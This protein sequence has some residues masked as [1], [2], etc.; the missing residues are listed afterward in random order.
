[1][2]GSDARCPFCDPDQIEPQT[3]TQTQHLS[4]LADLHP[5]ADGHLLIVTRDH[6]PCVAALPIPYDSE[7]EGL[8]AATRSFLADRY[9]PTTILEHGSVAQTVPHA[10]LHLI[11]NVPD[12]RDTL[13]H[14]RERNDTDG[15]PALRRWFAERGPYLYYA[16]DDGAS[17]FPPD[18]DEPGHLVR[19]AADAR[20]AGSPAPASDSGERAARRLRSEWQHFQSETNGAAA[21]VVACFLERDGRLALFKRSARVDSAP[22][23]WH[24]VAGYL[25]LGADPLDHALTEIGEETGLSREQLALRSAGEAFVIPDA[26]RR[27]RWRVHPFLFRVL[28]GEPHLNWEHD[29]LAWV[30]PR[31]IPAYRCM[32][33]VGDVYE[34]LDASAR[35]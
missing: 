3:V 9:G 17:I 14:G 19:L 30:E 10:H 5:I 11:P 31:M 28:D 4:L 23:R 29:E 16:C 20:R 18:R 27:I 34:S 25:P 22:G 24:V 1:M 2:S 26:F 12:F 35:G 32:P 13:A 33:W 7:L 6:L 21:D 8:I 15:W